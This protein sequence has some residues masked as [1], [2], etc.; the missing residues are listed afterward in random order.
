MHFNMHFNGRFRLSCCLLCVLLMGTVSAG[1]AVGYVEPWGR[2]AD[3]AK[4]RG[5][6]KLLA[7]QQLSPLGRCAD[8][9]ILFHQRVLTKADGPR[10]HFRPTSSRYMQLAIYR[11]GFLKGFMMG[12]D[13]LM[14]ENGE[15]WVY[16]TRLIDGTCY[17]WD[18]VP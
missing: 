14:R 7:P 1:A 5:E 2:D 3:L 11:Y 6:A 13:R 4:G 10:S 16:R 9:L 17:Q 8:L 18:P 12:C 15:S